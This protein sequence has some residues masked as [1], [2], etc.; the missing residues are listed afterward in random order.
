MNERDV[1]T[2]EKT[3]KDEGFK[4]KRLSQAVGGEKLGCSLYILSPGLQSWPYHYH[5][6]NEEAIFV[7]SGRGTIQIAGGEEEIQKGD[8]VSFPAGDD[9]AHQI[10]NSGDAELTY[11]CFSSMIEPEVAI[12]P[13]SNMVGV[14]VGAPPGGNPE[15]QTL[16]RF[17]Q[18][19]S[20][21]DYWGNDS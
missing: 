11:L 19:D 6:A 1:E 12:Y 20:E 10:F 9:G 15:E 21:V 2:E 3:P 7:L 13:E 16:K 4:R 14:F 8:Y 18:A 5:T 17:L